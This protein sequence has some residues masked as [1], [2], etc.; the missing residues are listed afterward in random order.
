MSN[1]RRCF[2]LFTRAALKLHMQN[3]RRGVTRQWNQPL[4]S[5]GADAVVSRG[6]VSA[7]SNTKYVRGISHRFFYRGGKKTCLLLFFFFFNT[8]CVTSSV[9]FLPGPR[10]LQN[11][12]CHST[13]QKGG[14]P[15]V[16]FEL[17]WNA[18]T[19]Y[20]AQVTV[21]TASQTCGRSS[22]FKPAVLAANQRTKYD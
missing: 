20:N 13:R 14:N 19:G 5:K 21:V 11:P 15:T 7:E 3:R 6:L 17:L 9:C 16:E 4:S 18:D 10:I 8:A 22:L 1:R 12:H 2:R